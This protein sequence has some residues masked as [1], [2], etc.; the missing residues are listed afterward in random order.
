MQ[1][2]HDEL[3]IFLAYEHPWVP[4]C[5]DMGG[6]TVSLEYKYVYE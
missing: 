2:M 4:Y 1:V 5:L 3:R 6:L